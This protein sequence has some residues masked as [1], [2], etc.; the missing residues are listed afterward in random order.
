MQGEAREHKEPARLTDKRALQLNFPS[1]L[2][3][4]ANLSQQEANQPGLAQCECKDSDGS[5]VLP[6]A[7]PIV[8]VAIKRGAVQSQLSTFSE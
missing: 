7:R 4:A 8:K 5:G 1:S 2:A 6:N 3:A